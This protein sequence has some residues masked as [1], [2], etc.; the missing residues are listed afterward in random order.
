MQMHPSAWTDQVIVERIPYFW[1]QL[2]PQIIAHLDRAIEQ[3]LSAAVPFQRALLTFACRVIQTGRLNCAVK[4]FP[5]V[6][7][8]AYVLSQVA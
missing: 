1:H 4:P 6:A 8:C 2:A 7:H 5:V 3:G